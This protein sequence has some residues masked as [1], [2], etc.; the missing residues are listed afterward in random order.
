MPNQ[1]K[2]ANLL[3]VLAVAILVLLFAMMGMAN[4]QEKKPSGWIELE[5]VVESS[6][7][8]IPSI[9]VYANGPLKGMVGWTLY[10]QAGPEWSQG[11]VG[12]T[13][14]PMTWLSVSGSLGI[15]NF[16]ESPLRGATSI[17]MGKGPWS[18]LSIQEKGGSGRWQKSV[19]VYQATPT[20]SVGIL[21]QEFSGGGPY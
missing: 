21:H 13:L 18:F 7:E 11:L 2:K 20:L 1:L 5:G 9:N 16:E 14:S 6:G 3:F 19:G 15:E 12:L 17:W 4:A 10:M 8:T